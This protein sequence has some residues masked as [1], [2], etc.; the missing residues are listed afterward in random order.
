LPHFDGEKV[1]VVSLSL[2]TRG[3]LSEERFGYLLEVVEGTEA[4]ENITN[5]RLLLS[6]WKGR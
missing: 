3:I 4:T 6:N 2:P 1:M 5:L